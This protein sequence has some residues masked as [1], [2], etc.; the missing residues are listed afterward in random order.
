[1]ASSVGTLD[2]FARSVSLQ[3]VPLTPGQTPGLPRRINEHILH[4]GTMT[5]ALNLLV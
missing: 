4:L 5:V 3:A 2:Y 1:M